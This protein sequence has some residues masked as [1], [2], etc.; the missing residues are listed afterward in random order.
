MATMTVTAMTITVFHM[1]ITLGV[2]SQFMAITMTATVAAM[3]A[4]VTAMTA[5]T[6]VWLPHMLDLQ[7]FMMIIGLNC[8]HLSNDD[9]KNSKDCNELHDDDGELVW[10]E[11]TK[12]RKTSESSKK[13]GELLTV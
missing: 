13:E 8:K 2:T 9:D 7:G 5:I 4:T 11:E 12:I 1:L 10:G 3:A 6:V